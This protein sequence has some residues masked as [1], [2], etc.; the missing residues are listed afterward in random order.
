MKIW[1]GLFNF[2]LTLLSK[3]KVKVCQP[4]NVK[5]MNVKPTSLCFS[6]SAACYTNRKRSVGQ[7]VSFNN[8]RSAFVSFPPSN[9]G[10]TFIGRV[11]GRMRI[12]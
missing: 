5:Q 10:H 12:P 1:L 4:Y 2:F 7:T 9:E 3:L 6:S 11:L 8:A